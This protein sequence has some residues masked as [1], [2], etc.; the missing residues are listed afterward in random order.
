MDRKSHPMLIDKVGG[1]ISVCLLHL[2]GL[3]S[4]PHSRVLAGFLRNEMGLMNYFLDKNRSEN[5]FMAS[6]RTKPRGKSF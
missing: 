4:I 1:F 3:D 2:L 5:L 6:S